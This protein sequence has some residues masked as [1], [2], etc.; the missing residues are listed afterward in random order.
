MIDSLIE[1][2]RQLLL[3]FNGYHTPL[4]DSLM[5]AITGKWIWVPLYVMLAA[6]MVWRL[7]WRRTLVYLIGIALVITISDQLCATWIRPAVGRL[8]P[9]DPENPFYAMVQTVGGYCPG[10]YSF[11][12]CHAANTFA[13]ATFLSLVFRMRVMTVFMYGWATL[14]CVSRLY[15]GV[16]HPGDIIAGAAIGSLIALGVYR[17][18][19]LVRFGR[20]KAAAIVLIILGTGSA[21]A[22]KFE[23]GGEF[24]TIFDNREGE[25]VHTPAQT[26]F[27][28]R[29]APEI[30]LSFNKRRHRVM[31]GAVYTQPI[32]CEWD[33]HRLSP[34]LYYRYKS[35]HLQGAL[36]MFPR[37][38]LHSALP[39]Y[40]VSDSTRYF[41]HNLRGALLQ[42]ESRAG[43]FEILCD[44]RGMQTETRREAFAV[45]GRGEW[46]SRNG[47]FNAG[48]TAMLNHL[49]KV[50]NAPDDQY[51]VDNVIANPYAGVDF[52]P[53]LQH[54]R[55]RTSIGLKAGPIA[56]VSRDRMDNRMRKSVGVRTEIDATYRRFSLRNVCVFC[57]RPLFPLYSKFGSQLSEGEPYFSSKWYC[58]TELS[59]LLVRW[60]EII[61][62]RAE[63]D[64]HVADKNDFMF[65]QRLLL[66]VRI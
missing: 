43:F 7:G 21:G 61:D 15:L 58:R 19:A 52:S 41:Q 24:A 50:K 29:L 54:L 35:K 48:G 33:G 20:G 28:T 5:M 4:A 64:F 39:E 59:A 22:Q 16:H 27:L 3:W 40:L 42:Y 66:T 32:G 6:L 37:T 14:V 36:G 55:H 17:L 30:G 45:I 18:C 51:V 56:S 53:L 12:S 26:Y 63:L 2:D 1:I 8:R 25:A 38:L 60:K 23:W 47:L 57:N 62:L 49:A 34:T 65:Y 11:P 31:A 46:H 9:A 13:L 10:S 44:W